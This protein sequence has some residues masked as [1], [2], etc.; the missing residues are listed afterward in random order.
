MLFTETTVVDYY[1]ASIK[2]FLSNTEEFSS[3]LR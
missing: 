3:V 1:C 2:L